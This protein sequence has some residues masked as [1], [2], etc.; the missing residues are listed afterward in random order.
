LFKSLVEEAATP[1]NEGVGFHSAEA[2]GRAEWHGG[3]RLREMEPREEG[4]R[5]KLLSR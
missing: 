1:L 4:R 3:H 2:Q 5:K